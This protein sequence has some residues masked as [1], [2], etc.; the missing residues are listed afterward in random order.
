VVVVVVVVQELLLVFQ[1]F[2]LQAEVKVGQLLALLVVLVVVPT[3][4]A[5]AL[6]TLADIHL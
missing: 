5:Q 1:V 6:E 4:E 3:Q 2:L